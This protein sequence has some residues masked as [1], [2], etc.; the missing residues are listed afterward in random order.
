MV[1]SFQE[2]S[3]KKFTPE[4]N[5][6][7][8]SDYEAG[9]TR[10]EVASKYGISTGSVTNIVRRTGR[11]MR[12]PPTTPKLS[13]D[14][15]EEIA[16]KYR[17]GQTTESLASEYGVCRETIRKYVIAQGEQIRS[18]GKIPEAVVEQAVKAYQEIDN[19]DEAGAIFGISRTIVLNG[20]R[21]R[22]IE[23]D[24]GKGGR[25]TRKHHFNEHFFEEWSPDM[26]YVLG[27]LFA[28]GTV[29][30][31]RISIYQKDPAILH[32][33]AR[34]MEFTSYKLTKTGANQSIYTLR[35]GSVDTVASLAQYGLTP[36]SKS[37]TIRVPATL[38]Y[39]ADF[40]RGYFDGDGS[41]GWYKLAR[42]KTLRIG[43]SCG[44]REFL[45]DLKELIPDGIGG[46]YNKKD[47]SY[48]LLTSSREQALSLRDW[49]YN[50]ESG[51][52]IE[53]KRAKLYP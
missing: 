24:L 42:T 5:E 53:R 38:Q 11:Q 6:M 47:H 10:A 35:I 36:G 23:I 8:A 17:E 9:A 25:K 19:A 39:P 1:Y 40:V 12:P 43:F 49:M 4:F 22:G 41:G 27:F 30:N 51:L 45:E 2:I 20:A 16:R 3:M 13:N 28:D 29:A 32:D 7:V 48:A 26:A 46:P 52:Y 44:S 18:R 50:S 14:I 37:L 33:I 15:Q 31:Q 21:A 34:V